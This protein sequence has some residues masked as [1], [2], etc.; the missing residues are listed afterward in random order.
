MRYRVSISPNPLHVKSESTGE[1]SFTCLLPRQ[2]NCD[3]ELFRKGRQIMLGWTLIFA[4]L[5]LLGVFSTLGADLGSGLVS[6]KFATIVC[7]VLFFACI[8]TRFARRR[9]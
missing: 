9:V 8:L 3:F 1:W 2:L 4:L 5:T 6:A 7:C